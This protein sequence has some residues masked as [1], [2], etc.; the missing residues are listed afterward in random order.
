MARVVFNF[1]FLIE[2]AISQ[3]IVHLSEQLCHG[4]NPVYTLGRHSLPHVTVLQFE[5]EFSKAPELW[6][7]LQDI[8][9]G[10]HSID[11]RGLVLDRWRNWDVVWLKVIRHDWLVALQAKAVTLLTEYSFVNATGDRFEPHVTL[12]GWESKGTMDGIDIPADLINRSSVGVR[13]GLGVSGQ[14]FQYER[15][16]FSRAR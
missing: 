1:G 12:A 5:E 10:P 15:E 11:F 7:R 2:E 13:L 8:S 14:N 16:L 4:Q 3:K 9:E 6:T